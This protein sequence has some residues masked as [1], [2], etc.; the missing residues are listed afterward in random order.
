VKSKQPRPVSSKAVTA[1][2]VPKHQAL[3][4]GSTISPAPLTFANASYGGSGFADFLWLAPNR[5]IFISFEFRHANYGSST[6]SIPFNF[7]IQG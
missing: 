6:L 4:T 1:T 2:K 7:Y 3:P 5:G